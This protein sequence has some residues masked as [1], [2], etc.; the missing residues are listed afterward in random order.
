MVVTSTG[1][2]VEDPETAGAADAPG[3]EAVGAGDVPTVPT[4]RAAVTRGAIASDCKEIRRAEVEA[5]MAGPSHAC[6]VSCRVRAE[7]ARPLMRLHPEDR[8]TGPKVG[9]PLLSVFP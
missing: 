9:P 8:L 5:D 3:A 4:R 6:E 7:V 1:A 2:R